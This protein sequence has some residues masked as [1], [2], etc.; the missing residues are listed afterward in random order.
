MARTPRDIR[1]PANCS[2]IVHKSL[3]LDKNQLHTSP[4]SG[5]IPRNALISNWFLR[6]TVAR[7]VHV[8]RGHRV[9]R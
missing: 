3:R 2:W 7:R 6:L 8:A 5:L 9:P 1:S 4:T